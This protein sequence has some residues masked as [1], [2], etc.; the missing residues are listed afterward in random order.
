MKSQEAREQSIDFIEND[1]IPEIVH[2]R[3]FCEP[4]SREFVEFESAT[5]RLV[6]LS[7]SSEIYRVDALIRFSGEPAN[8]PLLV[9]LFPEDEERSHAASFDA[10]QN[11]E[12]FYSEMTA[13]YGADFVPRCYLADL[14]RYGRPVFVLEDLE[15]VGYSQADGEL[16][17]DHLVL[18]VQLL[19][20]FHGRGL[21]LKATQPD[22]FRTFEARLLEVT[23]TEESMSHYEKRSSRLIDIV[24]GMPDPTLAGK[25]KSKLIKSPMETVK[26]IASEV[27]ELA[28]ICHGHFSHDNLLFKYQNGK[29]IDVKV[30]DWQ[31]MRY[32][33]PAVDLGPILLYNMKY[34]NGPSE[35]Q[36]M[37]TVY[38]DAVKSEYPEIAGE[39]L[40]EDIV[41]KL[42]FA[43]LILSFQEHISDDELA[44]II[45][46]AERLNIFD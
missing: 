5:V 15:A 18:C 7:R 9:K 44:R 40:R 43:C 39:G 38:V 25:V 27:N 17:V 34:E 29:P 32:C 41:D 33:S 35:L 2:D 21:R 13:K 16:D 31:T 6:E 8:F 10:Y 46:E 22:I 36:E 26:S 28:T 11:E 4:G 24:E 20:K 19:G 12:M 14:S 30:I 37:L 1:L 42:L 23:L 3:H 45:Q